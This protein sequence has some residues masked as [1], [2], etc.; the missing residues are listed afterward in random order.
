VLLDRNR[1]AGRYLEW[2]VRLFVVAAVVGLA[3]IATDSRWATGAAI[4]ILMGGLLL[5]F[6]SD[7]ESRGVDEED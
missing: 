2:K 4:V 5:R 1:T 3:G 6:L 7:P